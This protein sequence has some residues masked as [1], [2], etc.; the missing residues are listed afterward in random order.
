MIA[1]DRFL[2]QTLGDVG[3]DAAGILADELDLL[4]RDHVA[5]LLH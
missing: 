2:R 1:H 4:A 3:R 5:V